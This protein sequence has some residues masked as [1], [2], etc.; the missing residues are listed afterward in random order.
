[1]KNLVAR[2]PDPVRLCYQVTAFRTT[3]AVDPEIKDGSKICEV[4]AAEL[5][6]EHEHEQMNEHEL[7]NIKC[8]CSS[9]GS[10]NMYVCSIGYNK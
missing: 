6:Q 2:P 9:I 7:M 1:M 3:G 10:Y 4:A 5:E 8:I